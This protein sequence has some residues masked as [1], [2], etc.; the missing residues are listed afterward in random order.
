MGAPIFWI[1]FGTVLIAVGGVL[2]TYGWNA[3]TEEAQKSA[4]VRSVA[5]ELLVNIAVVKDPMFTETDEKKLSLFVMFPRVSIAFISPLR[6]L[7]TADA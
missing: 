7:S 5:A 6:L 1:I 3:K 4:M 2:A